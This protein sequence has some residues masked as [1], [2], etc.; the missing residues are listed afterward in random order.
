METSDPGS[1]PL[2][3]RLQQELDNALR[4]AGSPDARL[5]AVD[6][7]RHVRTLLIEIQRLRAV[8][9]SG[10]P[11]PD[12]FKDWHPYRSSGDF[13]GAPCLVCRLEMNHHLHGKKPVRASGVPQRQEKTEDDDQS[14]IRG[15][16]EQTPLQ[17]SASTVEGLKETTEPDR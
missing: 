13:P 16:G 6:Q 15:T 1:A 7:R 9:A 11:P 2:V 3:A 12:P 10:V 8:L 5:L 17:S 14:R 4:W